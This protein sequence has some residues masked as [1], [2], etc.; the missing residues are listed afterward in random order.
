MEQ[1]LLS[2]G[3]DIGTSTT[4]LVFSLLTIQ[5]TASAFSVPRMVITGKEIVYASDIYFTPLLSDT[6]INSDEI[7][8]I[9]DREY[10]KAGVKK[11]S[12]QTGAV[13]ITGETARKENASE[14]LYALSGYA[15][16]FVVAT[17]GPDLEG[18][19]AAKGAGAAA[20]SD[21]KKASVLNFDI[22]G[23]TSN[24]ALFKSGEPAATGC[25]DIGGRLIKVGPDRKITYI[26]QKVQTLAGQM[27]LSLHVGDEATE[28]KLS[29]IID[30]MTS[31]LAQSAHLAP[32]TKEFDLFITNKCDM[33]GKN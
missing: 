6:V 24:L 29:P 9:I 1:Q 15:G 27:G 4:Q 11:E 30:V 10:E 22:G 28:Q 2:V 18:I 16:D 12:I 21:A 5:N 20:F 3:I 23:G 8:R 33:A 31:V 19:I 26:T 7:R 14:V 25:L 32:K 13:I 17:A